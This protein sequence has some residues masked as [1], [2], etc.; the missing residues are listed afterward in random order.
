M[1]H[2][3]VHSILVGMVALLV[4]LVPVT[5]RGEPIEDSGRLLDELEHQAPGGGEEDEIDSAEAQAEAAAKT[6]ETTGV[7]RHAARAVDNIVVTARRRA[8]FLQDT[9]VAVT[10]LDEE[11]LREANVTSL[12]EIGTLV[13]NLTFLR[14]RSGQDATVFIR[15]VGQEQSQVLTFDPGVGI[16]VDGVYLA[17]SQGAILDLV[18]VEQVEVL[19]G[20][21]GTLF[22]K[23]T[24]GGA[25][26]ITTVKPSDELEAFTMVRA[27][28]R[29][30][31]QT[32]SSL[33]VPVTAGWLEDKLFTRFAFGS[34]NSR[35]YTY[36]EL[37]DEW[38]SDENSLGLLG[39]L[40][41][42]PVEQLTFDVSG[43]W[44][45]N[46]TNGLGGRCV[47][48]QQTPVL[49][50]FWPPSAQF[51]ADCERSRPFRF[52]S[53]VDGINDV[54][55]YGVW[56]TGTWD[57]GDL[58]PLEAVAVKSLSSW[59]QQ[60]PRL[61]EDYDM[62][63][64]AVGQSAAVGGSGNFVG[65]AGDQRQIS[66][67]LQLLGE[68]LEGDLSYVGGVYGFWEDGFQFQSVR[69]FP[70]PLTPGPS[71]LGDLVTA[72]TN[73]ITTVSNWS[74]ALFTQAT[75]DFT[76]W[77]S[78]TG[79]VRYTREEKGLVLNSSR[80]ELPPNTPV[81]CTGQPGCVP[82]MQVVDVSESEIFGA[83]TPMATL[84]TTVPGDLLE[85]TPL[86]H[87]MG[88][89]SFG[90]GFKSGGFNGMVREAGTN[91]LPAFQPEFLDSYEIGTKTMSFEDRLTFNIAAFLGKY[92]DQ[93]VQ[94]VVM[95]PPLQPGGPPQVSLAV[96]N[97]A[98]S[99]I[100]GLEVEA[101]ALPF[102]GLVLQADVALLDARFDSFLAPSSLNTESVNRAGQR[103]P[104]VP[105][106]QTHVAVQYSFP[107]KFAGPP[108]LDGWLTPRLEWYYQ[109]SVLYA[110][111]ELPQATQA[112]YNL[113]NTRIS[114]DFMDDRAQVAF[115][116]LNLLDTEYFQQVT[117]SAQSFGE[118][119]QFFQAPRTLG[120]EL[121]YRY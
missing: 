5:S 54:E 23:N 71:L 108:S 1:T 64:Q 77:L 57:V 107:L 45:R 19:R 41:F 68:A 95:G 28:S 114:Y 67:E 13:P 14:G 79:G 16:Y 51:Q 88:Y 90:R 87:L 27:G 21:Q 34:S 106:I 50:T 104:Y 110:G 24:V 113:L 53:N 85:S 101:I 94:S 82:F 38:W 97:A 76:D 11:T 4:A 52:K 83:T 31:V 111:P 7:S 86:S 18:D 99:T 37:R 12:D 42:L 58:G 66:Q 47:W 65:A 112:A 43:A 105:D 8:E 74:W 59:R 121:S 73:Q 115:W 40:R 78:L 17:R 91:E 6:G 2:R 84:A 46:H 100:K 33:N 61:R 96:N 9:P 63:A 103:F 98:R 62:T 70:G 75:Y 60:I 116:G 80:P 22:G 81:P 48:I 49:G 35:G 26:N 29:A 15:G 72:T 44:G 25:I 56:G 69:A 36:N 120:V 3:A 20:P 30:T 109:G 102:D 89:F 55:S 10:A 92:T 119:V 118:I 39:S 32:R 117:G 93:Q